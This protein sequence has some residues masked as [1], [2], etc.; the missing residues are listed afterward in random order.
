VQQKAS[1][2]NLISEKDVEEMK[3]KS[4]FQTLFDES[5]KICDKVARKA[6]MIISFEHTEH[7]K[8]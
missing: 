1:N 6:K 2:K 5:A 3:S 7:V 4:G 8:D